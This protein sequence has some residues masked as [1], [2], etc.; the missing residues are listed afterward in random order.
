MPPKGS[1][2]RLRAQ[3][4]DEIFRSCWRLWLIQGMPGLRQGDVKMDENTAFVF[5]V[6]LMVLAAFGHSLADSQ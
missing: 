4:C 6:L 5:V 1:T 2:G 3:K